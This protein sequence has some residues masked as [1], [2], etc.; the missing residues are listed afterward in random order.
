[1]DIN[2]KIIYHKLVVE[3]DI[4]EISKTWKEKIKKAIDEKL[5]RDPDFFGK[6]FKGL[7]KT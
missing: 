1:M 7:Q 4:P 3:K 2:F 6:P 5:S